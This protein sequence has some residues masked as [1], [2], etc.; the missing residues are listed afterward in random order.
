MVEAPEL[1]HAERIARLRAGIPAYRRARAEAR[2]RRMNAL[3]AAEF[4]DDDTEHELTD[5]IDF[6][7]E[8]TE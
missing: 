5:V 7:D 2:K 6:D 4:A 3:L 8:V 1:S